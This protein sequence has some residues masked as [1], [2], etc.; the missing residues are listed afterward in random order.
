MRQI[1]NLHLRESSQINIDAENDCGIFS[2]SF[3]SYIHTTLNLIFFYLSLSVFNVFFFLFVTSYASPLFLCPSIYLSLYF[4]VCLSI[5]LFF[6]LSLSLSSNVFFFL[7]CLSQC[8]SSI[9][10]SVCFSVCPSAYFFFEFLSIYLCV[11]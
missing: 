7:F 9:F 2:L 10:L 11:V 4:S 8:L 5:I 3:Y 1:S 6:L